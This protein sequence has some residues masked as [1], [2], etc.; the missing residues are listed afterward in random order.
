MAALMR[1]TPRG[2]KTLNDAVASAKA[3]NLSVATV[4]R[5]FNSLDLQEIK[6]PG[7]GHKWV[8]PLSREGQAIMNTP[9]PDG[10]DMDTLIP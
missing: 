2:Q 8:P 5:T 6:A 1:Y 9:S 10:S 3:K 4:A 7:P